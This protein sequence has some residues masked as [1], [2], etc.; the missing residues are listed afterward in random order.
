MFKIVLFFFLGLVQPVMAKLDISALAAVSQKYRQS[1][2]VSM[3]LNQTVTSDLLGTETKSSGKVHVA[4]GKFRIALS[5]PT[6]SLIVFDGDR[7]WNEQHPPVGIKGD[8]Q[9]TSTKIDKKNRGQL[10]IGQ[11]LSKEP[12]TKSFKITDVIQESDTVKYTATP[13]VR[14]LVIKSLVISVNSKSKEILSIEYKDEL[15]NLTKYEFSKIQFSKKLTKALFKYVP[16]KNA[17]EVKL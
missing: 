17:K 14:D 11:L 9:Y 10:L 13:L 8:V 12:I 2:M 5:E 6:K 7:I 4:Q 1:A 15:D 3:N 16:P